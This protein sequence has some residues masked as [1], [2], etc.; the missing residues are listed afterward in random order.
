MVWI[1]RWL[2]FDVPLPQFCGGRLDFPALVSHPEML[3]SAV[4]ASL[5]KSTIET[6][7]ASSIRG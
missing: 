4:E 7:K 6:G 5:A 1:G 3:A 2:A